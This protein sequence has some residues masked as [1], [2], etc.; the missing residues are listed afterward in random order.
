M[1]S[2]SL[3]EQINHD[4]IQ[5]A[6]SNQPLVRDVLRMVKT[7][8]KNSEINKGHA[9]SDEEIIDVFAKEVKQR[10]ESIT[11]F[12]NGGRPELAEK[13]QEEITILQKYLPEQL[14]EAEVVRLVE[15]A[16]AATGATAMS[17]MGKVMGALMPKVKGRADGNLVSRLVREKL[18]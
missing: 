3:F 13:E 9:L 15:E 12:T 1:S 17:D 6:K 14:E 5:A 4:L 11:S 7:A 10:Q 16:V 8:I 18:S 2:L